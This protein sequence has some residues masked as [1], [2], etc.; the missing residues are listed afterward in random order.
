MKKRA[1]EVL[2]CAVFFCGVHC[3]VWLPDVCR[4]RNV[5][6]WRAAPSCKGSRWEGRRGYE[7]N[8]LEESENGGVR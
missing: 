7:C 8:G 3:T 4:E 1:N 5:R 6:L 2:V